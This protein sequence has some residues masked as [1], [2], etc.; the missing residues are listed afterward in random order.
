MWALYHL[1]QQAGGTLALRAVAQIVSLLAV[2]PTFHAPLRPELG[3]REKRNI[4]ANR[5]AI[6]ARYS[7]K[8][9][10]RN[11]NKDLC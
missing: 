4:K 7:C 10:L 6:P 2:K 1:P 11:L 9:W 8:T 5:K 3:G